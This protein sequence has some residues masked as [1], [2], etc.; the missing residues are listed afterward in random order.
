MNA[1]TSGTITEL[2]R[3]PVKSM[4]GERLAAAPVGTR[5]LVGDRAFALVDRATGTI[6]SAK[7]PRKWGGLLTCR[8]AYVEPPEPDQALPPI[9]ITL[10]DGSSVRSDDPNVDA[11]LARLFERDVALTGEAPAE[12]F[13]EFDRTPLD[14]PAAEPVIR[15]EPFNPGSPA[16]AFFD[17]GVLHILSTATLAFFQNLYPEGAFALARFRPNLVLDFGAAPAA[18]IEH[19]WLGHDLSCGA[20]VLLH[21]MDPCPRCVVTTAAQGNL[22]RDPAILRTI[23][24]HSSAASVTLAPGAILPAVAGIYADV[25]RTGV[26]HEGDR[27]GVSGRPRD[28]PP[29]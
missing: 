9:V 20:E 21:A 19:A 18:C 25:L 28:H 26:I 16:G 15:R 4:Q 22:P 29:D 7:H 17:Y 8:A 12:R 6:A 1:T 13:R 5:G 3:Y 2:W 27:L 10:P 24:A 23:T 14:Q 11:V